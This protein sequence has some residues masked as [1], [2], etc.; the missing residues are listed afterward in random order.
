MTIGKKHPTLPSMEHYSDCP[1]HANC[2]NGCIDCPNSICQGSTTTKDQSTT[3]VTTTTSTSVTRSS[4]TP[5]DT[6]TSSTTSISTTE[7]TITGTTLSSTTKDNPDIGKSILVL[8]NEDFLEPKDPFTMN[9]QGLSTQELY[10]YLDRIFEGD[11]EFDISFTYGDATATYRSCG[12][13]LNG[14]FLVI[15]GGN[16]KKQVNNSKSRHKLS[17]F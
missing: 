9:L 15:G 11:V 16:D 7:S 8:G 6:T 4:T 5:L 12:A 1:C 13:T 17:I 10:W 2:P 14:E 3:I